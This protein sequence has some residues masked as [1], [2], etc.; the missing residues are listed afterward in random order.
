MMLFG[1]VKRDE[2]VNVS[3]MVLPFTCRTT[4]RSVLPPQKMEFALSGSLAR[5]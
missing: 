5:G 3:E 2:L 1:W 4:A